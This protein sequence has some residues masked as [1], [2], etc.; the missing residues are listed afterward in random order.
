MKTKTKNKHRHRDG[1]WHDDYVVDDGGEVRVPLALADGYRRDLV[2]SFATDT[3]DAHRP[4]FRIA[5]Q[6]TR[7]VVSS[8]REEMV[9]LAPETPGCVP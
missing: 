6:A 2:N 3:L 1:V 5:G 9:G 7:D 8:A 4:G